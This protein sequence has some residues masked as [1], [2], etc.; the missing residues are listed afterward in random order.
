MLAHALTRRLVT[1]FTLIVLVVSTAACAGESP[2]TGSPK[3]HATSATGTTSTET[4]PSTSPSTPAKDPD[5]WKAEFT[6]AQ[7]D[8]YEAALRRFESYESRSEPIW[9]KGQATPAAERLFKE[10]FPHPTWMSYWERLQGYEQVKVKIAGTPTVLWSEAQSVTESGSGVRIQQCVDYTPVIRTQAGS[11]IERPVP[12]PQTRT[13]YLSK[14]DG[15]DW[16]IFGVVELRKRKPEPCT[17]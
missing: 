6:P 10:F 3:G 7:L 13:I 15:Y 17:P 12:K 4:S 2:G 11:P 14:P 8:A 1:G 5:A 16:L 9:A